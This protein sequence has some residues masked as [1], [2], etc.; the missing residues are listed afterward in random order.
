MFENISENMTA[1]EIAQA[2]KDLEPIRRFLKGLFEWQDD[3]ERNGI[4]YSQIDASA[5]MD[6]DMIGKEFWL[7]MRRGILEGFE[8]EYEEAREKIKKAKDKFKKT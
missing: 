7:K 6:I 8:K 5:K 2:E 4:D 1:E 3:W